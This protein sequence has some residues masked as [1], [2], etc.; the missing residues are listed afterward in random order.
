[1]CTHFV[2]YVC[3]HLNIYLYVHVMCRPCKCIC[4]CVFG[5][6]A[7]VS[8]PVCGQVSVF[9]QIQFCKLGA[10]GM[11]H[12]VMLKC[13]CPH[14]S[15]LSRWLCHVQ[16]RVHSYLGGLGVGH[17]ATVTHPACCFGLTLLFQL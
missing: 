9:V 11:D 6:H 12:M 1:M 7:F 13:N 15:W 17:E 16:G 10:L 14:K 4:V 5:V 2:V 3:V 8:V